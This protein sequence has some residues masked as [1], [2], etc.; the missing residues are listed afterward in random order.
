MHF[1]DKYILFIHTYLKK[2]LIFDELHTFT[3]NQRTT[4]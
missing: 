1:I 4:I 2:I 3:L